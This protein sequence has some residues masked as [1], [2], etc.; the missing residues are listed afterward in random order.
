MIMNNCDY[1]KAYEY[2]KNC[3]ETYLKNNCCNSRVMVGPTGPM[4]P[5]GT[6]FTILGSY[7]SVEDLI[8]HHPTGNTGEAY[9]VGNDLYIWSKENNTWVDVGAIRGPQGEQGA[10]G[11]QGLQGLQGE[12][13]LMGPQGLQGPQ[14]EQGPTGP[15]GIQGL[16]DEQGPTGP[17]GIQGLQGEQGPTG[18][19][20]I[21]GLQGLQG[22]QGPTG[23]QGLQGLQGPR[24]EQG[25]QGLQ[26]LQGEPGPT[27][28]AGPQ[29]IPAVYLAT[30]NNNTQQGYTVESNQRIPIGRK[31]VDNTSICN[32]NA[33]ENTISFN[34][35]GVFRVEFIVN[36][37]VNTDNSFSSENDIIAI[38]FKKTNENIVYAGGSTWNSENHSIRIVGQGI[39]V[40]ASTSEEMELV[41]MSKNTINLT[42]PYLASTTST[43]YFIN[44]VVTMIIQYLG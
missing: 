6:S 40:I 42:T 28:P 13:G 19:Q 9:I 23:P 17:Q 29:E 7:D 43:S 21:Q 8:K 3:E 35:E 18:P 38:G 2:I 26:G 1:Q 44:P 30:F 11:P 16:Q 25:P 32:L 37:Y 10:T 12:Q 41:N 24:G 33:V 5:A 31:E 36:A 39:F 20:G 27:G 34:K 15:Q 4:G 22:E 14:G